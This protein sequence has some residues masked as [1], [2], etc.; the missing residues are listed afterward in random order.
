LFLTIAFVFAFK[1]FSISSFA[2][3]N[4][5]NPR[6][7]NGKL[8]FKLSFKSKAIEIEAPQAVLPN[9]VLK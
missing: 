6:A 5:S 3:Q 1:T 4:Y 9:S 7:A 8:A 2:Q